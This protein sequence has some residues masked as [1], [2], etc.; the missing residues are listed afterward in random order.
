MPD[1]ETAGGSSGS[2]KLCNRRFD[3]RVRMRTVLCTLAAGPV[4]GR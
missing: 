3:D 1:F 2:Q 4:S